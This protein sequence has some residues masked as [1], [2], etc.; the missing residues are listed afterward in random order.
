MISKRDNKIVVKFPDCV[1]EFSPAEGLQEFFRFLSKK[2][3]NK[4]LEEYWN[5]W[6]DALTRWLKTDP[7]LYDERI[8][9]AEPILLY[10][11]FYAKEI[12][13]TEKII[14]DISEEFSS[15]TFIWLPL[16]CDGTLID[17]Q[18]AALK[19]RIE[20]IAANLVRDSDAIAVLMG[21]EN[22]WRIRH[23]YSTKMFVE[24]IKSS[25]GVKAVMFPYIYD[26]FERLAVEI[27]QAEDYLI[28]PDEKDFIE[29]WLRRRYSVF[30]Y[31]YAY[32]G[33]LSPKNI[34]Q[35]IK[36]L[37]RHI[38]SL[39]KASVKLV[40][41]P[42]IGA[43]A[44]I[45]LV[46]GIASVFE[47]IPVSPFTKKVSTSQYI[48]M[49]WFLYYIFR[50]ASPLSLI[51]FYPKLYI[52]VGIVI[53]T[54]AVG[55]HLINVSRKRSRMRRVGIILPLVGLLIGIFLLMMSNTT[56]IASIAKLLILLLIPLIAI[57]LSCL[58]EVH[59]RVQDWS[60]KIARSLYVGL[61]FWIAVWV[62]GFV[63]GIVMYLMFNLYPICQCFQQIFSR[64]LP[65][66]LLLAVPTGA[67][68]SL[69]S[70]FLWEDKAF[71]E[72]ISSVK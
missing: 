9:L 40:I 28:K 50:R 48:Q 14:V 1:K 20:Y 5:E 47:N 4:S 54:V 63:S 39:I 26:G 72:Q 56:I 70:Q 16:Q 15:H 22:L 8:K 53:I 51:S 21:F 13:N 64:C 27:L 44:G 60:E 52:M 65:T 37:L 25:Q 58:V 30:H 24:F 71:I 17:E 46:I 29:R 18:I 19:R 3:K 66:F 10:W 36:N 57:F 23:P 7:Q 45:F 11:V 68:F 32:V 31:L 33:S 69:F 35:H 59:P 2:L 42:F 61:L 55:N 12:E 67:L 38:K 43:I 49:D 6:W 34:L 62:A 41:R